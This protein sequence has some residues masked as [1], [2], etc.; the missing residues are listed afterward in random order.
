MSTAMKLLCLGSADHV[1]LET[2]KMAMPQPGKG[3]VLV[4]VEA[5]SV[6][7]ID[8]KR[9]KGYG[10]RLLSLKG[11]GKFPLVLGNDFAGEIVSVGAGV[12]QWRPGE[13]VMG[14]VPT[15]K[16]GGAHATHLTVDAHLVRPAVDGLAS[17]ALAAFPYT[18]TTLWLAL[19]GAGINEGNAKGRKVLVHGASG[20]L[21][22]LALQV[23]ASWRASVTAICSTANIDLCRNFG[24]TSVWDRSRDCLEE[25]PDYFDACLNF[26]A[27]E[28][29]EILLRRLR[30]GALGYATTV[31]PLLSNVDRRGL[32]LG[33]WR[34]RQDWRRMQS[35]AAAKGAHYRWIIFQPDGNALDMLHQFLTSGALTLSVGVSVPFSDAALAFEHAA[36]QKRGRAILLP[37]EA[38]S[39]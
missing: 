24:A 23:L 39:S 35:L 4:R 16:K 19:R 18:F 17:N 8:V 34:S 9:A 12:R 32:L 26:G 11:A 29:E 7:P 3:E 13:R 1:Q 2:R 36:R 31:H 30:Q 6:N 14:L 22:Q 5:T 21:G 25:L 20:G 37:M 15:G 27:W 38:P 10:R 28:D 33:A